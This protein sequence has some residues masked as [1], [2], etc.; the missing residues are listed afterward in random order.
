MHAWL[1]AIREAIAQLNPDSLLD[2]ALAYRK[3]R[4]RPLE[5][6]P[7]LRDIYDD[8][9]PYIVIQKGAQ[10][11]ITEL[12]V[13]TALWV[14]DTGYA[15]RG[16]ALYLMPTEANTRDLTSARVDP[17][18]ERSEY[19]IKR[20]RGKNLG[21]RVTDRS[22]LKALGEG[23]VYFRGS[24]GQRQISSVDA[25]A[26]LLDEF[27]LMEE[28]VL[29]LA[30]QRLGSSRRGMVRIASTPRYPEAGINRLFLQSD[31][32]YYFLPCPGCGEMQRLRWPENID[33]ERAMLV[34]AKSDCRAP[35]DLWAE[36][37][38]IAEAPT[39]SRIRGYHLSRL[40]SPL[41]DVKRMIL[42]A[43]AVSLLDE[44]QF[45]NQVL[46]EV[47]VQP[48]GGLSLDDLD[49]CR[50]GYAL[51]DYGGQESFMGVDVG[52][53]YHVIIREKVD[54]SH[55]DQGRLWFAGEA[56]SFQAVEALLQRF[57][58]AC[59]V[60]D[61]Q[62][63]IH[64]ATQFA[65]SHRSQVWLATYTRHTPGHERIRGTNGQANYLQVN[66]TEALDEMSNRFKEG[67]VPL[68][69]TAR[70]LGGRLQDGVGDYY[71]HMLASKRTIEADDLGNYTSRWLKPDKPDHY[72][73]AEVYCMLAAGVAY[74]N[75]RI[76]VY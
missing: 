42:E 55:H 29:P 54:R 53:K 69:N 1:P 18:I 6:T 63:E 15:D 61:S 72:A 70:S 68:P 31:Q 62:P 52:K 47:Y 75:G 9:H 43:E 74:K 21:R 60:V 13:S 34:C 67:K 28:N 12:M 76:Q 10:V 35:M 20:L 25:D 2:W 33:F 32:R 7:A 3:I 17:A 58:V 41:A 22:G 38:W 5:L 30:L 23:H 19:L 27:D 39:N 46:G 45:Q 44:Q 56:D 37:Q 8:D 57:N 11:G 49:R 73:H 50:S 24:D 26:V 40:Y 65:K 16:N 71:R 64:L 36:G 14:A 48:G 59:C 66:R 4:G 51:D